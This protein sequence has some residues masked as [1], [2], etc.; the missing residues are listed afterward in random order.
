[1]NVFVLYRYWDTPDNEGNEVC[2]VYKNVDN[3]ISIM[4]KDAEHVKSYYQNDY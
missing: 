3:A 4:K 1:M 2:G